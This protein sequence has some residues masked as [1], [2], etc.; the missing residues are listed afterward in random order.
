MMKKSPHYPR[1]V[2]VRGA[3]ALSNRDPDQMILR[4]GD[5]LDSLFRENG[6]EP[7]HIV[8]IFFSQTEDID[9]L[10][11][12]AAARKSRVGESISR[13][14]LFCSLEPRYPGSLPM[15]L[16]ILLTYYSSGD[17]PAKPVYLY[18][19]EVLRKDMFHGSGVDG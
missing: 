2:S 15:T 12:A 13:T 5:L 11:A 4:M 1:L 16:R 17:Q 19:A 6:V 7:E 8:H 3:V 18:G 10:N 14:P 9:F